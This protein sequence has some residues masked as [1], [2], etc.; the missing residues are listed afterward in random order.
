VDQPYNY[1]KLEDIFRPGEVFFRVPQYQRGYTWEADDQ[2]AK[3]LVDLLEAY[4]TNPDEDYLLGQIILCPSPGLQNYTDI[5]DGQQRLTTSF[6][7][8][9]AGYRL[10]KNAEAELNNT[11]QRLFEGFANKLYYPDEMRN[12]PPRVAV[13]SDGETIIRAI[14]DNDPLPKEDAL[15]GYTQENLV[16]A[17]VSIAK[18]LHEKFDST[19][20]VFDFIKYANS[21]VRL[22]ALNVRDTSQALRIFARIN[23]R[24]MSLDDADLIKNLLFQE[25]TPRDYDRISEDWDSAAQKIFNTRLKRTRSMNFLLKNMIGIRTGES[26]RND[27][28]FERWEAEFQKSKNG[29]VSEDTDFEPITPIEFAK[30]LPMDASNLVKISKGEKPM[31]GWYKGH[32]NG[33]FSFSYTQPYEVLLA[34][35]NKDE[36]TFDFVARIVEART[37]LS[38]LAEEKTQDYERMVHKW[39]K[40]IRSI[41]YTASFEEVVN[42]SEEAT[43][44]AAKLFDLLDLNLRSLSYENSGDQKRIRYVLAR[45]AF[46]MQAEVF[47]VTQSEIRSIEELMLTSKAK[48]NDNAS[49]TGFHIEHIF[50]K[51]LR[52]QRFFNDLNSM[53]LIHSLGN[54][55]LLNPF[56][57]EEVSDMLPSEEGKLRN[58]LGSNLFLNKLLSPA[59]RLE[60]S[61]SPKQLEV[62]RA[63][64]QHFSYSLS[65][66]GAEAIRARTDYLVKTFKQIIERDLGID[67]I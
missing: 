55:T 16:A 31:G 14:L 3:Y 42:A 53:N 65:D 35:S 23:N 11:A 27:D 59:D 8:Q 66:W 28:L 47:Q 33:I 48:K 58:F 9:L 57:N 49:K 18:F 45:L 38:L 2:V 5:V 64:K 50:P 34:A 37:M 43:R 62:F 46:H 4:E 15:T 67:S 21:K 6:L 61:V 10:I 39:A 29:Q 52:Q 32:Q 13:A 30:K 44:G 20:A 25:V 36:E 24:G 12:F 19:Q 60:N 22:M 56:D 41:P 63:E 40:S 51:A 54:L 26:I 7:L 17:Y 1:L